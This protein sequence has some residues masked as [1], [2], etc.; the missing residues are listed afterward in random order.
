M[1]GCLQKPEVTQVGVLKTYP[2][3]DGNS[4]TNACIRFISVKKYKYISLSICI[5]RCL[6]H[7]NDIEHYIE[8]INIY[9]NNNNAKRIAFKLSRYII[10]FI[11]VLRALYI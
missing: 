7:V 8:T 6:E 3:L 2:P 5:L 11:L 4:I 9:N 1:P 10:C